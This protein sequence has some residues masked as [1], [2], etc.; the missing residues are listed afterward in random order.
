MYRKAPWLFR[1]NGLFIRILRTGTTR[2]RLNPRDLLLK[3]EASPNRKP[4]YPIKQ[5]SLC[6][7]RK[8]GNDF[9]RFK[10]TLLFYMIRR[11]TYV[12]R[13]RTGQDDIVSVRREI[14]PFI[15]YLRTIRCA[16]RYGGR[17][18]NHPGP[19][20]VPLGF[21][22]AGINLYIHLQQYFFIWR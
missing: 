5:V 7:W 6:G 22:I 13:W 19:K 16:Y 12:R 9:T 1:C 21:Y 4:F 15:C 11:Q 20:T 8:I 2:F 3:T 10:R 17:V 14:A 18:R